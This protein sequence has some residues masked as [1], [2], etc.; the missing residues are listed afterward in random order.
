MGF[1][2]ATGDAGASAQRSPGLSYRC[3]R[4]SS[5]RTRAGNWWRCRQTGRTWC[6]WPTSACTG[7][8][9]RAFDARA[10]PGSEGDVSSPVFSPDGREVAYYSVAERALKRLHIAGGTPFTI[11]KNRDRPYGLSW[12]EQDIVYSHLWQG[13]FRV[14]STG[15]VPKMLVPVTSDEVASSPQM[16]PGG[17]GVLFSVRPPATRTSHVGSVVVQPVDGGVRKTLVEEASTAATSRRVISC[18]SSPAT[19]SRH[20][21]TCPVFR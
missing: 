14:P 6:M 18:T 1:D 16:L 2:E 3:P 20:P 21:S 19:C 8:R 9:C 4:G 12:S 10:I 7:D 17:R 13:I 5:S 11:A 15:G